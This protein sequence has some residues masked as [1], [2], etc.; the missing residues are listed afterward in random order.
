MAHLHDH[1]LHLE[2]ADE[3]AM[4]SQAVGLSLLALVTSAVLAYLLA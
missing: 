4:L 2:D 3:E 1:L